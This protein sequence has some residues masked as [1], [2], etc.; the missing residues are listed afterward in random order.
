MVVYPRVTKGI[1]D[2]MMAG[3]KAGW[4]VVST[5]FQ[6]STHT[7]E[8]NEVNFNPPTK[9]ALATRCLQF[10]LEPYKNMLLQD[11]EYPKKFKVDSVVTEI[12]HIYSLLQE[13]CTE[14]KRTILEVNMTVSVVL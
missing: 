7:E 11:G 2:R 1:G 6:S 10:Y 13:P 8:V 12:A 9:E 5:L 14:N 4:S 3:L